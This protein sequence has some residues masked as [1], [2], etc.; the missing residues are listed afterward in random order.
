MSNV[1]LQVAKSLFGGDA[2]GASAAE[3]SLLVEDIQTIK[4]DVA[5]MRSDIDI[6]KD[7]MEQLIDGQRRQEELIQALLDE[8]DDD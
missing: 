2:Q 8:K 3:D 1:L 4:A 6:L 7:T 5:S